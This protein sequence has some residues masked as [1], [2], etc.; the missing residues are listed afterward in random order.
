MPTKFFELLSQ[1]IIVS[2]FV[3]AQNQT[4]YYLFN[5]KRLNDL[6]KKN[7]IVTSFF[8]TQLEYR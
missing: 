8:H 2:F 3:Y 5:H 6:K 4:K 7:I 1:I